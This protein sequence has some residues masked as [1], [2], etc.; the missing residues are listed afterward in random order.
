MENMHKGKIRVL[1]LLAILSIVASACG[2]STV[3]PSPVAPA[4]GAPATT[5]PATAVPSV[6]PA[7]TRRPSGR[8]VSAAASRDTVPI[9]LPGATTLGRRDTTPKYTSIH[10]GQRSSMRS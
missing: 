9:G 5:V 3:T 10:A 1:G 7:T 2:S 4:S 8:P 6:A